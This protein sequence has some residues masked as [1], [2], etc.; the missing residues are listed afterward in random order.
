MTAEELA[1][2]AKQLGEMADKKRSILHLLD[3]C[4]GGPASGAAMAEEIRILLHHAFVE[5]QV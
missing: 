2:K 4:C 1:A 5:Q 3:R